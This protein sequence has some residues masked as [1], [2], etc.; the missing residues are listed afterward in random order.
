MK[1]IT[2]LI[3]FICCA[4]FS[5]NGSCPNPSITQWN[6]GGDSVYFDGNN[7]ASISS[8]E[9][10]YNLGSTF[11]PGDGTASTFSFTEFPAILSGLESE[12]LYYFTIRSLSLIHI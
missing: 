5:Q 2:L 12:S 6:M 10:E 8:Y 7:D 11:T 4:A 3:L 9:V 1:K